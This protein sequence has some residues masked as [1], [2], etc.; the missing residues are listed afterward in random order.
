MSPR[1]I[2]GPS[3]EEEMNNLFDYDI[4]EYGDHHWVDQELAAQDAEDNMDW[5]PEEEELEWAPAVG[6]GADADELPDI[7]VQDIEQVDEDNMD[8][9]PEEEELEWAPAVGAG[10]D[11]DEL[12]DINNDPALP[13]NVEPNHA[14]G[15]ENDDGEG[16][17]GEDEDYEWIPDDDD[18]GGDGE[19]EGDEWIPDDDDEL[20][21]D[22]DIDDEWDV[23]ENGFYFLRERELDPDDETMPA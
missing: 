23:D 16:G 3:Q 7:A 10:A 12:L 15:D 17:D 4:E 8:W 5:L 18:M 2:E 22:Q 20:N 21:L 13:V 11:A 14:V 9:L 6:A 19:D 1:I